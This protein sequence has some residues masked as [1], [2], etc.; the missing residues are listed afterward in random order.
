MAENSVLSSDAGGRKA[1]ARRRRGFRRLLRGGFL[2]L[3]VLVALPLLL[4]PLYAV[5]NPPVSTVMLWKR[6]GGAP[7][8]KTWVDI[9]KISPNLVRAVMTS[10]DA[11]FCSHNG[12]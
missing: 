3:A 4:I 5:V 8:E 10:E 6:L 1:A 9:E 11:R 7:I 12:I 2:I